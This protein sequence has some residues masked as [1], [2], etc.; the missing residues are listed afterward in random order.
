[1]QKITSLEIYL[2]FKPENI[3]ETESLEDVG[4]G[5]Y[6]CYYIKCENKL[7]VS[8]S[9]ISLIIDSG[10]FEINH[11]FKPPDFL[12]EYLSEVRLY[13][14]SIPILNKLFKLPWYSTW[15]T[16]DKRI[17][18][19][20]SFE[21]VTLTDTQILFNPDFTINNEELIINRSAYYIKKFINDIER[22][23]PDYSHIV[24]TGGKD[25]QIINLVPK[26]NSKNWYIF[27]AQPNYPLVK[28]WV[29]KNGINVNR[30]FTHDGRN[31]ESSEDFK[32]K[33]ICGDLYADPRQIKWMP[34]IK[35]ITGEFN[36]KC[37]F[38]GGTMSSPA[39]FYTGKH[40]GCIE[41]DKT[42]FF[43]NHFEKTASWLGNYHQVFKNF[44][45]SPYLSPYHSP[46]IWSELYQHF[47]P[48]VI[49]KNADLRMKIGDRLFEKP[50]WWLSENPGPKPYTYNFYIN[51]YEMYL[52]YINEMLG[53]GR[54]DI[55]S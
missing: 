33:V 43:N 22:I 4:C 52:K 38:W 47:D 13:F 29:G 42:T 40:R 30:I 17:K 39:H 44:T 3:V 26:L 23:F 35:K 41:K 18:K 54:D 9:V 36:D 5:I 2:K 34:T 50:V 24:L 31:E 28:R 53:Q 6:P 21:K 15:E 32:K 49:T 51:C 1:M 55:V 20:K 12:K 8:T 10:T 27:S 46:E 19:L 25:S 7:K 16:I 14:R 48:A 37:I 45:R 11:N